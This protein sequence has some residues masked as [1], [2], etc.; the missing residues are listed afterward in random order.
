MSEP[1]QPLPMA[2][3]EGKPTSKDEVLNDP[4]KADYKTG[5]ELLAKGEYAQAAMALH[6]A[7]R[8]FEEQ[9]SEQGVANAADRLGDVCLAREEYRLALDH[10][11]RAKAICAQQH[12]SFSVTALNKKMAVCHRRLGEL[13]QALALL[14]DVFDHDSQ[15]RNPNGTVEVLEAIA[16]VYGEQGEGGKA[17]DALRTIAGIHRNFKHARQ[18]E[19]YEERA[20]QAEQG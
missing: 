13:D 14:F 11:A 6:N 19:E 9:G 4:A 3:P 8:G 15:L 12:D 2:A 18:A 1:M 20:R 10:F 17:A 7:L 5:R 16:G